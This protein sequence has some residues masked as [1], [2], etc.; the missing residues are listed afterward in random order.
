VRAD[1]RDAE[2]RKAFSDALVGAARQAAGQART[3]EAVNLFERALTVMPG[4]RRE[5]LRE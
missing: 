4:R 2:A 3:S 5:L 1:P